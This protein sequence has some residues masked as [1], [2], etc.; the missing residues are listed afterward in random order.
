MRGAEK[1]TY[2]ELAS[3]AALSGDSLT[4]YD[5]EAIMA[6]DSEYQIFIADRARKEMANA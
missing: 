3:Y 1:L 6:M 2:S 4:P 5:V